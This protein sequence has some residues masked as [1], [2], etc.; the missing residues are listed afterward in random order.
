ML[1][2]QPYRI[3]KGYVIPYYEQKSDIFG[4]EKIQGRNEERIHALANHFFNFCQ[5]ELKILRSKEQLQAMREAFDGLS[6]STLAEC[7]I[8]AGYFRMLVGASM[9]RLELLGEIIHEQRVPTDKQ[10]Y[11]H[12]DNTVAPDSPEMKAQ[13]DVLKAE[14]E[15]IYTFL[16]RGN[17]VPIWRTILYHDNTIDYDGLLIDIMR[18]IGKPIRIN[19]EGIEAFVRDGMVRKIGWSLQSIDQIH[20]TLLAMMEQPIFEKSIA[21]FLEHDG[22]RYG[23]HTAQDVRNAFEELTELSR[24][25]A[26]IPSRDSAY[27]DV[28]AR[29]A[30]LSEMFNAPTGVLQSMR[31][32][33]NQ[34]LAEIR[35]IRALLTHG[36]KL[37]TRTANS[38]T[39]SNQEAPEVFIPNLD[40]SASVME[41]YLAQTFLKPD[42]I[43]HAREVYAQADDM[44]LNEQEREA[45]FRKSFSSV[46]LLQAEQRRLERKYFQANAISPE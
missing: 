6:E 18:E 43:K 39:P 5:P 7:S 32:E 21:N 27:G 3:T 28:F 4:S 46:G 29:R 25:R 35:E 40:D 42:E 10:S 30:V 22:P 2:G 17:L 12:F 16:Q 14:C 33:G 1:E 26:C 37:M 24:A 15:T 31:R 44:H 8:K 45:F 9:M 41:T 11:V 20:D 13:I 36:I 34:G 38:R 19:K 23:M